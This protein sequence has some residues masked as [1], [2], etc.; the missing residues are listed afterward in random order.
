MTSRVL[1]TCACV[2]LALAACFV[3]GSL[4]KSNAAE[5]SAALALDEQ[6]LRDSKLPTDGPGLIE[7]FK[8][9]TI[10]GTLD[11]RVKALIKQLG[12][13]DFE[14]REAASQGLIAIGARAKPALEKALKETDVEIIRRAE[15]CLKR[16]NEG[17]TATAISAAARVLAQRQPAGAVEVLLAY[18]PSA[19]DENVGE[20]VRV[21][22][23]AL[24]VRDGKTDP[25]LI[26][27]LTDKVPEKRL[28]AGVALAR[29][30]AAD[31]LPAVRKLLDDPEVTVRLRVG[32]ALASVRQKEAVPVLIA[33]LDQTT[34]SVRDMGQ[35]EDLL[36]RLGEDTAP[37]VPPGTDAAG[38]KK[39]REA[40]EG[41]WKEHGPKLDVAKLEEAS[42][43]LGYTFI[44]LLDQNKVVDLDA[45]NR[46]RW[47]LEGLTFPLDAQLLPGERVLAAEHNA[48]RVTERNKKG[49]VLWQKDIDN[50]L[51]AQRLPNGNTFI[52]TKTLLTEITKEGKEVFT[53]TRPDGA[54]FMRAQKL[55]NGDIAAVT[56]LGVTRFIR[57]NA[58]LKE[59]KSFG[60]DV[61][62]SG[63]RV[64]VQPNGNVLIP[65]NGNNRVVE[66]DPDGRMVW[67][68]NVD[69]PIQ[70][71]RLPNG[72]TLVTS[73][74]TNVGA[75]ELDRNGKMVWQ[76]KT[77]T[78]VTRAY[79]R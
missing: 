53:Y 33:L 8:N 20:A 76:Y 17:A 23:G 79:R 56:Q 6:T 48:N 57:L 75:V 11:E 77:D 10:D 62:T 14:K 28:A 37:T 63:G 60:V 58:E 71:I 38:R 65:E 74:S 70:A 72:H 7:F 67:E 41:W 59:I 68:A 12:D 3:S 42:R 73:M 31:Q 36:F 5:A 51:V 52:A 64:D 50:P 45:A 16:I 19:E 1:N 25:V 40:W 35:I 66:Y 26:A 47:S 30:K 15:D 46:P 24:A 39:F 9:R 27:A 32:L 78:R 44:V 61:R 55:R 18:A 54:L 22:L 21:A 43:T 13:E 34:L 2:L 4:I 69:Q 49:E 29:A